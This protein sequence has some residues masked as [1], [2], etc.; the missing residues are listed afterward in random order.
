MKQDK[1][2]MLV[3]PAEL[4]PW[5]KNPRHNDGAVDKVAASIKE[6]GF[7]A[8]IVARKGSNE[9]IAGHTRWKAAQKLGLEVV[10]VRF[11]DISDEKAQTMALADNKL[12]EVADWD[13][14][15]LQEIALDLGDE[16]MDLAGFDEPLTEVE[17][18][19]GNTDP[20]DAP[21]APEEPT[22]KPGDLWIL[23]EHRLL[24]GDSTNIQ[25]V[26][27]LMDG[28]KANMV[29][30]DPPYG[31]SYQSNFRKKTP[32][33]AVL[34]NDDKIIFDWLPI[35]TAFS[36]GF[37]FVWTTWKVLDQWLAVT[38]DF[39]P[40]TN[41]IVWSKP[42]GG[43]GDLKGTYSTDHEVALVF[44]RGAE[45]TG[46]RIGSVW[47][48]SKDSANSYVHPTQKP[49]ALAE[50]ALDTATRRGHII[51]D[52]FG[53]SGSTL[54]A[55]EKTRRKARLM[56]LDPKYCDVIVKRWEDFTGNKAELADG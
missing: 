9:I 47:E 26:E 2:S 45:L 17:E 5:D 33:F 20:D 10:P 42:G 50:Q 53:G 28:Q 27:K 12:G 49:V 7:G 46:K 30:T 23:G 13:N 54:I 1:T 38:K 6:L 56:E 21:E 41:M 18:V 4:V 25:H 24:C 22:T 34:E 31:V 8:P 15:L 3:A 32:Q 11:L 43:L 29:F 14:E 44:N 19:E 35:A 48:I 37:C 55:C 52:F 16:L 40:L 36:S 39:A 51:L